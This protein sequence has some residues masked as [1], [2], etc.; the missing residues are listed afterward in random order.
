[1]L[2]CFILWLLR[3]QEAEEGMERLVVGVGEGKLAAGRLRGQGD[4]GLRWELGPAC[5]K[6]GRVRR[7]EWRKWK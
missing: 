7:A 2:R 4:G 5:R 1:M 3:W 6:Q